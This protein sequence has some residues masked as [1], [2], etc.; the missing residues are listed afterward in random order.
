M[1]C[2]EPPSKSSRFNYRSF[3]SAH[4]CKLPDS[5]AREGLPCQWWAW[6]FGCPLSSPEVVGSRSCLFTE[7]FVTQ[8]GTPPAQVSQLLLWPLQ[9]KRILKC[10]PGEPGLNLKPFITWRREKTQTEGRGAA[11]S[12]PLSHPSWVPEVLLLSSPPHHWAQPHHQ[13]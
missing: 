2:F 1:R 13:P 8:Q 7:V 3:W 10:N 11:L 4:L 6:L 5:R 9:N 12:H